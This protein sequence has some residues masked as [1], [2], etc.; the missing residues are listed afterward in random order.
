MF[1]LNSRGPESFERIVL[2]ISRMKHSPAENEF[3]INSAR[4]SDSS[5]ADC[6]SV[7]PA[8]GRLWASLTHQIVDVEPGDGPS[9]NTASDD[10]PVAKLPDTPSFAGGLAWLL[11]GGLL[12]LQNTTGSGDRVGASV[13]CKVWAAAEKEVQRSR[14]ESGVRSKESLPMVAIMDRPLETLQIPPHSMISPIC[15][16]TTGSEPRCTEKAANEAGQLRAVTKNDI[17]LRLQG[18][19][20]SSLVV[21]E[22]HL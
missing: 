22:E 4:L 20:M 15:Q 16:A 11:V 7:M 9:P 6:S 3:I 17:R 19:E 13:S 2:A 8:T 10:S 14:G 12:Q 1:S 18:L 5:S 21:G